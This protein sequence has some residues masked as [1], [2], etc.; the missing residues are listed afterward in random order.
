MRVI[1]SPGRRPILKNVTKEEVEA[2]RKQIYVVDMI[3]C[4]DVAKIVEKIKELSQN[5]SAFNIKDQAEN[6]LVK[7]SKVPIVQAKEPGMIKMDK[8]C[9]FVIIPQPKKR[10]IVVE[11]YS[12][13]NKLLRIIEGKDARSIY[14]TIIENGG[15]TELG[16][17][18][19]LGKELAKAELSLKLG[20][21]Y[22]QDAA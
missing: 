13:D 14:H 7:I 22:V 6:N 16:H 2:F 18:A 10:V 3:G 12:Y 20:F 4:E 5:L 15:V 9:Y 11:H 17:A 21:K 8:A 1:N 19:Y